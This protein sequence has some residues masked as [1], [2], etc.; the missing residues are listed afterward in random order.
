MPLMKRSGGQQISSLNCCGAALVRGAG[1]RA[2]VTSRSASASTQCMSVRRWCVA[3]SSPSSSPSSSLSHAHLL[4]SCARRGGHGA[5][6]QGRGAVAT[7]HAERCAGRC[8]AG[9]EE[10]AGPWAQAELAGPGVMDE[11][12]AVLVGI[13]VEGVGWRGRRR[14][15]G[16]R[17]RRRRGWWRRSGDQACLT[18]ACSRVLWAPP[19][20]VSACCCM[21]RS[22]LNG[23][24]L[25]GTCA[26]KGG[27]R[28]RVAAGRGGGKESAGGWARVRARLCVHAAPQTPPARTRRLGSSASKTPWPWPYTATSGGGRAA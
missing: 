27:T 21:K 4:T 24:D 18:S 1:S 6:G 16:P 22:S 3:P 7:G 17:R 10:D 20:W 11:T 13:M 14:R 9:A 23:L 19:P 8:G 5:R 25:H 28:P 26:L 15:R 12:A 2:R